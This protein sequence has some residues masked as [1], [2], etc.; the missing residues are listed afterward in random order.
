MNVSVPWMMFHLKKLKYRMASTGPTTSAANPIIWGAMK[1]RL[2]SASCLRN[3]SRGPARVAGA[4]S[5]AGPIK[6]LLTQ[7]R[8]LLFEQWCDVGADLGQRRLDLGALVPH[9]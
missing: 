9:L 6:V 5:A 7:G 1:T 3:E 4:A 2:S 8:R